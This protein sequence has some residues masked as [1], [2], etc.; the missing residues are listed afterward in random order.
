MYRQMV[1]QL[2][3]AKTG[4]Q[5]GPFMSG[6]VSGEPARSTSLKPGPP[7]RTGSRRW[8]PSQTARLAA[9]ARATA[10]A[11]RTLVVRLGGWRG[12][13]GEGTGEGPQVGKQRKQEQ[14]AEERGSE[15]DVRQ[16]SLF[17]GDV[18]VE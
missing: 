3:K 6:D 10:T 2:R 4:V 15:R 11:A 1:G 17:G 8:T 12:D 18:H 5:T 9:A 16:R 13:V 14:H 7:P